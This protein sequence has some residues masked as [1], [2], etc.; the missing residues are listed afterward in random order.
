MSTLRLL[1]RVILIITLTYGLVKITK[2]QKRAKPYAIL[3][4]TRTLEIISQLF[5]LW[6]EVH[7]FRNEQSSQ[8]TKIQNY[9]KEKIQTL[10]EERAAHHPELIKI[11]EELNIPVRTKPGQTL[12]QVIQ[13]DLRLKEIEFHRQKTHLMNE[14]SKL[15]PREW[16]SL[17]SNVQ[18]TITKVF[19]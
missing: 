1:L 12:L 18:A 6:A 2:Q 3:R 14:V 17:P 19:E 15:S 5:S 16:N 11:C 10:K 9:L 13:E 4:A 7:S 8:W